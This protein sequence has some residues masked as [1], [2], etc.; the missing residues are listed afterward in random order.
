MLLKLIISTLIALNPF[1]CSA[2]FGDGLRQQ[3][4]PPSQTAS[5]SNFVNLACFMKTT[6]G[7]VIDLS[8]LCDR[9]PKTLS[10]TKVATTNQYEYQKIE[11]FNRQ[12]YG[13]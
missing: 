13:D 7:R 9:V 8:K 11:N 10:K 12:V 5:K 4:S 1:V 6:N 3:K 2:A